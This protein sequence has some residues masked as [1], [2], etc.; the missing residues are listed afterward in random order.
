MEE[1]E[2]IVAKVRGRPRKRKHH[3]IESLA[4]T[5]KIS[6]N[7]SKEKESS[8]N[9]LSEHFD[10]QNIREYPENTSL[11]FKS[12]EITLSGKSSINI[13]VPSTALKDTSAGR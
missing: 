8:C 7:K 1:Q 5:V 4:D 3:E 9:G 12:N 6:A 11:K 13:I 10:G 2:E